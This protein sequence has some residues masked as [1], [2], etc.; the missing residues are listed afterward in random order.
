VTLQRAGEFGE[1][2]HPARAAVV[3]LQVPGRDANL[4]GELIVAP[5]RGNGQRQDLGNTKT[6]ESLRGDQGPVA[7]L[8]VA[9]NAEQAPFFVVGK[10][11]SASHADKLGRRCPEIASDARLGRHGLP[12]AGRGAGSEQSDG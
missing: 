12:F 2:G 7:R 5:D 1:D 11:T 10:W 9:H 3:A 4:R 6:R 8:E